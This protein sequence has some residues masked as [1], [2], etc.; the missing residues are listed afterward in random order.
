MTARRPMFGTTVPRGAAMIAL[1]AVA[2]LFAFPFY[3]IFVLGTWPGERVLE[4]PPHL[5]FGNGLSANLEV[6]L[7]RVPY[8]SSFLNSLGIALTQTVLSLFF[9]TMAGFAFAK[10]RFRFRKQLLGFVIATLA[11]PGFLNIV[12][13]YKMMVAFGWIN[14]W[15]PL[16]VPG[17]AGAFGIFL[18]T[19]FLAHGLPDELLDAGAIDGL[20]EFGLLIRVV[21]PLARPGMAILGIITFIGSWNSFTSALVFLPDLSKTTL[22]VVLAALNS[23]VDNNLGALMLGTALSLLPMMAIFLVFSRQIISGLTAGAVKG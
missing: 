10:Y 22:P 18:M 20:G 21:F 15:L 9:C 3:Y 4:L 11:V 16:V 12:P 7:E 13:F 8:F 5:V 17:M 14:T 6:L 19:Q 23:R 1:T 2:L